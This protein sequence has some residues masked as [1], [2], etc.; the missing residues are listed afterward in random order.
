MARLTLCLIAKNEEQLL[1]GCLDSVRGVADEI[2]L[3]DTGSTDRTIEIAR[4]AGATILERPWDHDFAAP[5]NLAARRARGKFILQLDADERLAPGAGRAVRDALKG[6][7]FDVAMVRLHNARRVDAPFAE[8]VSGAE[9]QGRPI[10][11]PRIFRNAPD[12]E[13]KGAIHET[14]GEWVI[15]RGGK[16]ADLDADVV[17]LGYVPS[18]L[19]S[20]HKR[21]RNVAL[22]RR[23]CA[24]EPDDVTPRGYLALELMEGG[25]LAAAAEAAAEGWAL[26]PRQPRHRCLLRI[27]V[28]R[29]LLALRVPDAAT[30]L[31]TV[32][33]A[34]AHNGPH[35]DFDYLR[36]FAE[37]VRAVRAPPRSPERAAALASAEGALRRALERLASGAT[38]EFLGAVNEVRAGLHLGVVLLLAGKPSDALQAFAGALRSEPGN[39][40]ARVGAAE[41]L[42]E[43]GEARR[44]LEVVEPALGPQPDGWLVAASAA[45]ALGAGADAR[46]FLARAKERTACGYECLH[47]WARHEAVDRALAAG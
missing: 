38:Y 43:L 37:E 3:V 34:E 25:E 16:R 47:R 7:R 46:V 32:D 41:A 9:R 21:E 20:R 26:V 35:P 39:G 33:R 8:V 1:P 4:A 24:E 40:S 23:R 6:A 17:H 12:L 42:L 18:L 10:L 44:A 31:E 5:R 27:S 11:L 2:V 15:R 13:W 19:V 22:L 45:A 14:V 28:A 36:G 30:V 29:G